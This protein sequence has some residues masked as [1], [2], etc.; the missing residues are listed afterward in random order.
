MTQTNRRSANQGRFNVF[1]YVERFYNA[2][3]RPSTL[4]YRSSA[5]FEKEAGLT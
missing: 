3:H 2:V 1:D 5:D 4:G